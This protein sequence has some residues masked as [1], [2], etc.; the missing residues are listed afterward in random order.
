METCFGVLGTS[1]RKFSPSSRRNKTPY[2]NLGKD[3]VIQNL[4]N[5]NDLRANYF[6]LAELSAMK[7]LGLIMDNEKIFMV[8][9]NGKRIPESREAFYELLHEAAMKNPELITIAA[10]VKS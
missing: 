9:Q 5:I 4:V 10:R 7:E 3:E 6:C 2:V 8:F 1:S